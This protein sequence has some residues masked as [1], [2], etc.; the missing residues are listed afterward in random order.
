MITCRLDP[1]IGVVPINQVEGLKIGEV[2]VSF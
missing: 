2:E 1:E